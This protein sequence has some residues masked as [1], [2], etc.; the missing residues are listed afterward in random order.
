LFDKKVQTVIANQKCSICYWNGDT[1]PVT[2]HCA[3]CRKSTGEQPQSWRVWID[4]VAQ[5][6]ANQEMDV[7]LSADAELPWHLVTAISLGDEHGSVGKQ[8]HNCA[9]SFKADHPTGVSFHWTIPVIEPAGRILV[10]YQLLAGI[11]ERLPQ[12]IVHQYLNLLNTPISDIQLKNLISCRLVDQTNRQSDLQP[13]EPAI[14][15]R[16]AFAVLKTIAAYICIYSLIYAY[17]PSQFHWA[18]WLVS[19][20]ALTLPAIFIIPDFHRKLPLPYSNRSP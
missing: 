17:S 1:I 11:A 13:I 20:V 7:V 19:T 4:N 14:N 3:N 6:R 15:K 18:F 10:D 2:G 16:L 8:S 9:I 5:L 12:N